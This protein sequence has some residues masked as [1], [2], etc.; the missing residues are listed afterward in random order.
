MNRR[1][2]HDSARCSRRS[3]GAVAVESA[4]VMS[5][6]IVMLFFILELGLT[7]VRYNVLSTA[8]RATARELIVHGSTSSPER[9]PWG[10]TEYSGHAGDGSGPAAAAAPYLA[11]LNPA[12]VSLNVTWPDGDNRTGDRV[13]VT[14]RY[15]ATP[16]VP[17]LELPTFYDLRAES[18]MQIVH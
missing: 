18:T 10:P 14:L 9:T 7:T 1:K 15:V 17:L 13:H 11:T 12:D 6:L 2:H 8:A 5:L 4:I 3:C 16:R